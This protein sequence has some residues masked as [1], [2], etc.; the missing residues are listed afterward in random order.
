MN[1][2]EVAYIRAQIQA[3]QESA[4]RALHSLAYGTA[5]HP[6][7]TARMERIGALH[8]ALKEIVGEEQAAQILCET[9]EGQEPKGEN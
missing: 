9:L 2:S 6:F 5:Q 1:N 7:I 3:E 8:G 4:H